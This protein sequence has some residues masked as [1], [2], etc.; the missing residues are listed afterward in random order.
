MKR[1]ATFH[2]GQTALEYILCTAAILIVI[3]ILGTIIT[4]AQKSAARTHELVRSDYP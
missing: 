3:S 2:K 4:A 1:R